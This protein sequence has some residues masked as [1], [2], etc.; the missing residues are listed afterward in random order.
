MSHPNG[1]LIRRAVADDA[2]AVHALM[3]EFAAAHGH[4]PAATST[5]EIWHML[6]QR[7]DVAV[8]LADVDEIRVGY[9]S[10]VVTTHLWSGRGLLA[11]DDLYVA[12]P[13]RN[14]GVGTALM[15]SLAEHFH[16]LGARWEVDEGDLAVQRFSLR[17]GARLRRQVVARWD[18]PAGTSSPTM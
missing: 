12:P 3:R 13:F 14:R 9:V 6:L 7:G 15:G 8:L 1:L 18:P 11:V 2:G 16:G 10:A 17:T 4:L 5:V